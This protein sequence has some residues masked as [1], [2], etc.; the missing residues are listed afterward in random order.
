M[1][2]RTVSSIHKAALLLLASSLSCHLASAQKLLKLP[3]IEVFGGYSHLRFD[4]QPL[5]FSDQLNLD[6]WNVGLSLPDLYQGFGVAADVSGH[7]SSDMEEYNFMV[8]PQYI[9]PWKSLRPFGHALFGK[10]RDRLRHP[11][12]TELEPSNL[13]RAVALGGGLDVQVSSRFYLRAI[14]ADYLITNVFNGTQHNLRF[15]TG[16]VFRF[17]KH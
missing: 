12:S 13:A 3:A 14:Q 5:G 6:G 1:A 7:Y 9:Y 8:G 16:L 2:M 15:S 10:A 17:G 11:G 4:S